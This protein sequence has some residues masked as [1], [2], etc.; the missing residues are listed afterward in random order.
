MNQNKVTLQ[1]V[2][3]VQSAS[4]HKQGFIEGY[5]QRIEE[6]NIVKQ[7]QASPIGVVGG[8]VVPPTPLEMV[9]KIS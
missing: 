6:E 1:C 7:K 9:Q 2:S 4:M 5:S 8:G 3:A